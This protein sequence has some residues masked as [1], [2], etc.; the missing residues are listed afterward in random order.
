[1]IYL[2]SCK[3]KEEDKRMEDIQGEWVFNMSNLNRTDSIVYSRTRENDGFFFKGDSC[4]FRHRLFPEGMRSMCDQMTDG[5]KTHFELKKDTLKVWYEDEERWH[6]FLI[7]NLS[8][9]S[10]VLTAPNF[11]YHLSYVRRKKKQLTRATFDEIIVR[12]LIAN[13]REGKCNDEFFYLN[14]EGVFLYH[15]NKGEKISSYLILDPLLNE[16]FGNFDDV[17]I[18]LLHSIYRDTRVSGRIVQYEITFLK[19][20]KIIKR[21]MDSTLVGPD[22]LLRG[23][24]PIVFLRNRLADECIKEWDGDGDVERIKKLWGE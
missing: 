1:M 17:D 12:K 5:Y 21:V 6:R 11:R 23:Y 18:K 7:N 8:S 22:E 15:D 2:F 9:D 14:K 19:E 24:I 16:L 3:G 4:V 10:L 20:G 13:S